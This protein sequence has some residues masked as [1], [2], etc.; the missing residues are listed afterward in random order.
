MLSGLYICT[1]PLCIKSAYSYNT[2]YI[3]IIR[4]QTFK[5]YLKMLM[6]Y[7]ASIAKITDLIYICRIE[8]LLRISH[9]RLVIKIV[10]F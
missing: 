2:N 9:D 3:C 6:L 10:M 4:D 8:L 5:L 1:V 7:H